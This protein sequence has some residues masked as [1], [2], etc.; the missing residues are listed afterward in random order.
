MSEGGEG[1]RSILV[2]HTTREGETVD[3][4]VFDMH[5]LSTEEAA[6]RV[7]AVFPELGWVS[8]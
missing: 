6:E 8:E 1:E 4:I 3:K 2:K 7:W 5:G